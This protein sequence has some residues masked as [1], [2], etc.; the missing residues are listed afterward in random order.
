MKIRNKNKNK[1]DIDKTDIDNITVH[2]FKKN[3]LNFSMS[4]IYLDYDFFVMKELL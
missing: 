1:D 2:M 3:R 4:C